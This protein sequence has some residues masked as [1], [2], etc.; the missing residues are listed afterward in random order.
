MRRIIQI[1]ALSKNEYH[2]A[3]LYALCDDNTIWVHSPVEEWK[4]LPDIPQDKP[5][6]N[7]IVFE[8]QM[9]RKD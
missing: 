7:K 2:L 1:N 9:E 6:E 8:K 4:K 3:K 5:H